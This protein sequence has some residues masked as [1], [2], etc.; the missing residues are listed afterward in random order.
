MIKFTLPILLPHS[1]HIINIWLEKAYFQKF[2]RKVVVL[3]PK[4][5]DPKDPS[6]LRLIS[7]FPILSKVLEKVPKNF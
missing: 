5:I 3:I 2:W 7:L 6:D 1:T 4:V